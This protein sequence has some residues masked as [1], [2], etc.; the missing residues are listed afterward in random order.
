MAGEQIASTD[1]EGRR[2]PLIPGRRTL[3]LALVCAAALI[4]SSALAGAASRSASGQLSV[5]LTRTVFAS[6]EAGAV[7]LIYRFSKPSTS[8]SYQLSAWSHSHWWP[9]KTVTTKGNFRG[10]KS[11]TV[12]RLFSGKP[13]NVGRYRIKLTCAYASK[14]IRFKLSNFTAHLT[15]TSFTGSQAKSVKLIYNYSTPTK[16]FFYLLTFKKG[17]RWQTVKTISKRGDFRGSNAVTVSKLFAGKPLNVGNYRLTISCTYASKL[18]SFRITKVAKAAVSVGGGTGTGTGSAGT[19]G[20]SDFTITGGA[21]SLLPGQAQPIRLTL[22]NPNSAPIYVTR[23]T[24]IVSADST[25]SG[26]SS[27]TNLKLTQSD[28]SS[29]SPITI[30]AGGSV[31]LIDAP[32]APEITLL[33]LPDVNQ[34]VCMNKSF[35]LSYSGSAHS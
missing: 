24:V 18:V 33:N 17:A 26:C 16:R 11:M 12:K 1:R 2:R 29:A 4:G 25:P 27:A 7:K 32:R 10:S 19:G 23:I 5:R 35:T 22:R 21:T 9:L 8:F 31:T 30:P 28:A 14:L 3:V 6:S 20:N 13:L 34:N 15:K